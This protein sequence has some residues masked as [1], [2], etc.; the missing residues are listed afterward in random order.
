MIIRDLDIE[1]VAVLPDEAN[2]ILS[3]DT[4][5]MLTGTVA[6]QRLQAEAATLQVAERPR[7]IQQQE[8]PQRDSFERLKS[9][10]ALLVEQARGVPV[11]KASY[12]VPVKY[13]TPIILRQAYDPP[14]SL[15]VRYGESA[16][17]AGAQF[18]DVCSAQDYPMLGDRSAIRFCL[19]GDAIPFVGHFLKRSG[20]LQ[21]STLMIIHFRQA[22]IKCSHTLIK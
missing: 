18:Q 21:P 19:V 9:S 5:A 2:A 11:G 12:Q 15:L 8:A 17:I 20:E 10:N 14:T 16:N 22:L 3:I 1:C 13:T 7:L 6:T 4:D